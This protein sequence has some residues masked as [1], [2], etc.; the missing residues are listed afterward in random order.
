M[1]AQV[2]IILGVYK[3]EMM[4]RELCVEEME[5]IDGGINGWKVAGGALLV[6]LMV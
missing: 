6:L 4:Y 2:C 1:S 3:E 5:V